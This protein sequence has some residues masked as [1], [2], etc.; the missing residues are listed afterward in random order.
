MAGRRAGRLLHLLLLLT[1][2]VL[3]TSKKHEGEEKPAWAKK[4]IRD[5][6]E[7]DLE[8]LLEQWEVRGCVLVM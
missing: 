2:A 6:S 7:A 8:R 4:D 1:L 5:Y 3:S